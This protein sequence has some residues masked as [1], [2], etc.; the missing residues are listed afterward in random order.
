[1][2]RLTQVQILTL[3]MLC[4]WSRAGHRLDSLNLNFPS[5]TMSTVLL[6][7]QC[8]YKSDASTKA[9]M[10]QKHL[11][12]PQWRLIPLPTRHR[13]MPWQAWFKV[14]IHDPWIIVI[15]LFLLQLPVVWSKNQTPWT[16]VHFIVPGLTANWTKDDH[17]EATVSDTIRRPTPLMLSPVHFPPVYSLDIFS[18][19]G[20]KFV[21]MIHLYHLW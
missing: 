10:L 11:S 5:W 21:D 15:I 4:A 14:P 8:S 9:V 20:F 1:M 13:V 16:W 12:G 3:P 19:K 7:T 18:S 6:T 17:R 2:V